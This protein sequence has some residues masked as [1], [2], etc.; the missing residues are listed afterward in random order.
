LRALALKL[1]KCAR[2]TIRRKAHAN[3]DNA[4]GKA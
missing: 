1:R 2:A 3:R 4:G